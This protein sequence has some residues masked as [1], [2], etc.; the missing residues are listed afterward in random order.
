MKNKWYIPFFIITLALVGISLDQSGVAN[1]EIILKFTNLEAYEAESEEVLNFVQSQLKDVAVDNLKI[2]KK[3]DGTLKITYYSDVEVSTIKDLLSQKNSF[4][5][6]SNFGGSKDGLPQPAEDD[7]A[8]YQIDVFEIQ[9]TKDFVG[10]T[11][12]V[13]DV[14]SEVVRFFN[15]DAYPFVEH[16][17]INYSETIKLQEVVSIACC[18]EIEKG[19][20]NV[21]QVRAGPQVV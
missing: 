12:T 10:A 19:F 11:G 20:C 17:K 14:K 5:L 3:E 9:P 4:L 13:V 7:I 6:T 2:Q 16:L 15:P 8:G 1:Q 18:L 21:P